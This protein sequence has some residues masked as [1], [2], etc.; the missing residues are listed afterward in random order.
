MAVK[1]CATVAGGTMTVSLGVVVRPVV[2]AV[3]DVTVIG[4]VALMVVAAANVDVA[5]T[6]AVG[7]ATAIVADGSDAA[8]R[9]LPV[10]EA[11]VGR[12]GVQAVSTTSSSPARV[13]HRRRH[14]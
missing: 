5:G 11:V 4:T 1:V 13:P 14:R 10:D 12:P 2:L 7:S 8:D 9:L 3:L 6:T